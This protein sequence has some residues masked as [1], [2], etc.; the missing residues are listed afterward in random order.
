[1]R[2]TGI[3]AISAS[4]AVIGCGGEPTSASIASSVSGAWA[5]IEEHPGNDFEMTLAADGSSL[6]GTGTFVG[7]AG[8]GGNMAVVGIVTGDTVNLDFTLHTEF[9]D[10]TVTSTAHFTGHLVLPQ[11]LRGTMQYGNT[12]SSTVAPATVFIRKRY[13]PI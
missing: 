3:L 6:S 9:T 1:M 7:E 13:V 11:E 10:R 12:L 2:I 8:P 4:W 5:R